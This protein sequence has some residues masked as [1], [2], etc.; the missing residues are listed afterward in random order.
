[1]KAIVLVGGEGTRLR[2]LTLATP[3]QMLP[4]IEHTMLERVLSG[5]A[6]H[7]I[8]E[9]VL[10]LGYLPDAFRRAYPDGE[11]AGV[12]LFYAVEPEPLDTAGAIRFAA[13]AARIDETFL[14][15]N[16]DVLTDLDFSTLV[17]FHRRTGAEGT[18]RLFPVQDPSAFGV[19]DTDAEGRVRAF[20]EKPPPGEAPTNLINAGA[21]V[22]EPRVLQRIGLG[23]RTSIERTT[24]PAMVAD[25][26][27][28][29]MADP[30]YWLDTGTPA[31]FLQAHMDLL[32]G[33]RPGPPCE[34]AHRLASGVWATG[35][36]G[37]DGEA[38]A[39]SFLGAGARIA[40]G[41]RVEGSVIGRGSVVD[42]GAVVTGSVLMA[43]TYVGVDAHVDGSV[44]GDDAMVGE[45]SQ[46]RP[47]SVI[48]PGVEIDRGSVVDG[49][50]VPG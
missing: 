27:L 7:G 34:G 17:R 22:F 6:A 25:G 16:G 44:L 36:P 1:V 43:R 40:P 30:A 41:A 21:Y 45:G 50:R 38:F 49:Q 46:L 8:D 26:V 23:E 32:S 48:G 13:D 33:T 15:V 28:F 5:L 42:A 29:A 12:R 20:I 11:A 18:L 47:I 24:F 3:K 10:S 2:P 14:V 37:V 39:P 35:N 9:A 31:D 4:I 19:V